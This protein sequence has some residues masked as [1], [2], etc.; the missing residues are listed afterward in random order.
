MK[1]TFAGVFIPANIWQSDTLNLTEKCVLVEVS[2]IDS[3]PCTIE[4]KQYLA[5]FIGVGVGTMSNILSSLKKKG[6][7]ENFY[8]TDGQRRLRAKQ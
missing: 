1:R 5:S 2:S 4:T 3:L 7:V 8:N 6:F